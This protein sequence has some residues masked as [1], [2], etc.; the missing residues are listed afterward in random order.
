MRSA[1][2]SF[3]LEV[4]HWPDKRFGD[5]GR[6]RSAAVTCLLVGTGAGGLPIG[7]SLEA[8]LR[9]AV[10]TNRRLAEQGLD[11]RVL[12]D[13]MEFLELYEDVAIAAADASL[14]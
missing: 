3:A 1:L 11:N 13:R 8:I 4:A 9:A 5:F 7:D 2:L 6:P 14:R 10:C 12:I